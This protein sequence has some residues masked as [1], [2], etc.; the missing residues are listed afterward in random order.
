MSFLRPRQPVH[1]DA[2]TRMV[3]SPSGYYATT[4]LVAGTVARVAR[5]STRRICHIY[6]GRALAT[7]MCRHV[8]N[9]QLTAG[10]C[11]HRVR[12][13]HCEHMGAHVPHTFDHTSSR[14]SYIS[15]RFVYARALAMPP[16]ASNSRSPS[17]AQPTPSRATLSEHTNVHVSAL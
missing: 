10:T 9:H 12:T 1:K 17:V 2:H 14:S 16:T 13:L 11:A 4:A 8:H 7:R 3:S 15:T 5:L 6:V